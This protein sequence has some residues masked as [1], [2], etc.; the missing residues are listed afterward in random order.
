M[1]EIGYL[2]GYDWGNV[3]WAF[4]KYDTTKT[5]S[6]YLDSMKADY[7]DVDLRD[8][9]IMWQAFDMVFEKMKLGL[10]NERP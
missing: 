5:L 10:V 7:V 3:N 2:S 8:A 6:E 1:S 9:E 4:N